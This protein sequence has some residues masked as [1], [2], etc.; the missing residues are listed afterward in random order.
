M[1]T[2]TH[3][4]TDAGPTWGTSDSRPAT[5]ETK[6]GKH[7]RECTLVWMLINNSQPLHHKRRGRW[8]QFLGVKFEFESSP[9]FFSSPSFSFFLSFLHR[10]LHRG[11]N[12]SLNHNV[13]ALTVPT[14]SF[15]V[16]FVGWGSG[17]TS[18]GGGSVATGSGSGGGDSSTPEK[19]KRKRFQLVLAKS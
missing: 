14:N 19:K 16:V 6:N 10:I 1:F 11:S 3:T 17:L 13:G 2:H 15:F 9:R 18:R 5:S 12:Q 8:H 7:G 4:L